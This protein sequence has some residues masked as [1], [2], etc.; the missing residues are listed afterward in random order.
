M[1]ASPHVP[2]SR[3]SRPR[4]VL[5]FGVVLC[6]LAP[7]EILAS[8]YEDGQAAFQRRDYATAHGIWQELASAGNVS[9]QHDLAQMYFN[10]HGVAPDSQ[11]ALIWFGRAADKGHLHSL[12]MLAS[13][14]RD[15]IGVAAD[16]SR[17]AALFRDAADRGFG[18]AQYSFGLMSL[19][20]E[21]VSKDDIEALKWLIVAA[22]NKSTDSFGLTTTVHFLR[23]EIASTLGPD[24]RA[25]AANRARLWAP[26]N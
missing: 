20:G 8:S 19:Q 23:D 2:A 11:L 26:R 4:T 13:M 16:L 7:F 12:Y 15:G 14:Y 25:E 17:S 24:Q 10:G 9:A 5:V 22:A 18:P 1:G 3:A 6:L 21:G